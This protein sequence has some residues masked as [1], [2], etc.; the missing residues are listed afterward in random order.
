MQLYKESYNRFTYGV[1]PTYRVF[2]IIIEF[3]LCRDY[4]F[5]LTP[6]KIKGA[7]LGLYI[8]SNVHV[9]NH[10]ELA[11][12]PK[13]T[14]FSGPHCRL[15]DYGKS[16]S[17][18]YPIFKYNMCLR[19]LRNLKDYV[20]MDSLPHLRGNIVGFIP[21]CVKSARNG[22]LLFCFYFQHF[23][24]QEVNSIPKSVANK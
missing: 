19:W 16:T 15:N 7:N 10:W 14:S 1:W 21:T 23:L 3:F 24:L 2:P 4:S 17:L 22:K 20:Y 9:P 12:T 6:F 11:L 13:L 8:M 5:M 18:K